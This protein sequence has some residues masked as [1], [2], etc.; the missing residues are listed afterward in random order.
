MQAVLAAMGE[1]MRGDFSLSFRESGVFPRKI[2]EI[3]VP[4]KRFK[5]CIGQNGRFLNFE[6]QL[7]IHYATF[8]FNSAY[9]GAVAGKQ[10]KKE[11]Q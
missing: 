11:M 6:S 9:S 7:D 4:E 5:A 3:V 10:S 8:C 1:S 2:W